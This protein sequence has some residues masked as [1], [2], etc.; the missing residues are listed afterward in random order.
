MMWIC[1]HRWFLAS[2]FLAMSAVGCGQDVDGPGPD[3]GSDDG[4]K[5]FP[6][7]EALPFGTNDETGSTFGFY[8]A[9]G[10]EFAEKELVAMQPAFARSSSR[11]RREP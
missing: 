4:D 7:G 11:S 9:L 6:K 8:G 2:G 10:A 1:R 5:T 3:I